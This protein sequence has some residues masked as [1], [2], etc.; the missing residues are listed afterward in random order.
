MNIVIWHYGLPS[1]DTFKVPKFFL[2]FCVFNTLFLIIT[3]ST[4]T[5]RNT[6]ETKRQK[7][8]QENSCSVCVH[9]VVVQEFVVF[10]NIQFQAVGNNRTT[11]CV[12]LLNK[13]IPKNT[14]NQF[15]NNE[16]IYQNSNITIKHLIWYLLSR[17]RNIQ[18]KYQLI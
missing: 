3:R 10:C 11:N 16:D 4:C 12:H 1:S 13:R 14:A 5:G 2:F 7:N 17:R 6:H 18:L 15:P 9:Q 8:T